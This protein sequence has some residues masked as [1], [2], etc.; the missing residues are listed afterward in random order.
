MSSPGLQGSSKSSDFPPLPWDWFQLT[1]APLSVGLAPGLEISPCQ[2]PLTQTLPGT[3]GATEFLPFLNWT[4]CSRHPELW[5]LQGGEGEGGY[6]T[7]SSTSP[8][9]GNDSPCPSSEGPT[10][11][12]S[13]CRAGAAAVSGSAHWD[14]WL[15]LPGPGRR[16]R[17]L[18]RLVVLGCLRGQGAADSILGSSKLPGANMCSCGLL[19]A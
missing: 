17:S 5:P 3:D 13:L 7:E 2:S 11:S 10:S 8:A 4:A 6:V 1:P 12:S 15:H 19:C 18:T 9:P 14:A 16:G